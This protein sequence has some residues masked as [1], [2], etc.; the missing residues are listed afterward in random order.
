MVSLEYILTGTLIILS[1]SII[2]FGSALR[3]KNRISLAELRLKQIKY[4][5]NLD[6][7]R[8]LTEI[9]WS[10]SWEDYD[11]YWN[12]YSPKTNL[13]ANVTRRIARNYYVALGTMVRKGDLDL[14]LLY[15]MN[16]SGVTR[17][18]EKIRPIAIEFRKR[19][20][21]PDYLE[22]VEY[23][24]ERIEVYRKKRGIPSPSKVK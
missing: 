18:W 22:P 2:Y 6:A 23:L 17:Y 1:V 24:A 15:E 12:K 8:A 19:N 10:W 13:E 20:S 16:P 4:I 11:D 9:L 21:Y 14:G 3:E 5:N 7:D